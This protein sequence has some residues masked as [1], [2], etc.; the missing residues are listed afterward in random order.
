MFALSAASPS[1]FET[2]G[3]GCSGPHSALLCLNERKNH[4]NKLGNMSGNEQ[5]EAKRHKNAFP[6]TIFDASA[7]NSKRSRN[8]A[9]KRKRNEIARRSG[10]RADALNNSKHES[11]PLKRCVKQ[12]ASK[13]EAKR[14]M[15]KRK[16][17][18]E[19][20]REK[21]RERNKIY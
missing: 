14:E 8:V 17:R 13:S 11:I 19:R 21:L 12:N 10:R 1:K 18:G 3:K 15:C 9:E 16:A 5:R 4:S 6:A 7:T 20:R 2:M